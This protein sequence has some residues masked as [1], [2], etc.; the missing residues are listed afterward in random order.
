MNATT[1][2]NNFTDE[3][4]QKMVLPLISVICQVLLAIFLTILK[5]FDVNNMKEI[6]KVQSQIL[7]TITQ[8]GSVMNTARLNE[9]RDADINAPYP[10]PIETHRDIQLNNEYVLRI[11]N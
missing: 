10:E 8:G 7:E 3:T 5:R 2:N 11:K 4:I 9:V 6:N 1:I